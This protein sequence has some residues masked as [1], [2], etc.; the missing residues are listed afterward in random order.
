VRKFRSFLFIL[1]LVT[2]VL[3]SF[4]LSAAQQPDKRNVTAEDYAHA[5]KFLSKFTNPLIFGASVSPIWIDDSHFWYRNTIPEGFEFVQID[6]KKNKGQERSTIK[7]WPQLCQKQ[8][9]QNMNPLIC[10]FR[11]LSFPR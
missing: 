11:V 6:T 5:E 10:H 7:N 4:H 2:L 3:T 1:I 8:Q 9:E